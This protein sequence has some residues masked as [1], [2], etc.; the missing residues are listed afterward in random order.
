[1]SNDGLIVRIAEEARITT[2]EA[3]S[4]LNATFQGLLDLSGPSTYCGEPLEVF[5]VLKPPPPPGSARV[6]PS[7]RLRDH[8]E[9]IGFIAEAAGI[10]IESAGAA[11]GVI[12]QAIVE[13]GQQAG[14][15][16]YYEYEP[17]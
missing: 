1:M 11:L 14:L 3:F 6:R 4:A 9:L 7:K 2:E 10:S 17:D 8:G 12:T 5:I 15:R 13:G 16:A